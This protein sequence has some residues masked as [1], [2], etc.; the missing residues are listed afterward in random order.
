MKDVHM[1]PARSPESFK[2]QTK[3][4]AIKLFKP[5]LVLMCVQN[6]RDENSMQIGVSDMLTM[7]DL[8]FAHVSNTTPS[9][10]ACTFLPGVEELFA[11]P[12]ITRKYKV[13][14]IRKRKV[15]NQ[16][17]MELKTWAETNLSRHSTEDRLTRIQYSMMSLEILCAMDV[18]EKDGRIP[19]KGLTRKLLNG[20]FVPKF[21]LEQLRTFQPVKTASCADHGEVEAS[22]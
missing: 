5:Q 2:Y 16:T 9:S 4:I 11:D 3:N 21:G 17:E 12:R 8:H 6:E 14:V 20:M 10:L 22:R 13:E 7:N 19:S 1:N 15:L 18:L